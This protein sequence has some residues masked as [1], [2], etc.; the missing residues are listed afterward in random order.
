MPLTNYHTCFG[1]VD[2]FLPSDFNLLPKKDL[3]IMA[4][5]YDAI[6]NEI[7]SN[8]NSVGGNIVIY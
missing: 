3:F 4:I 7:K 5:G 2:I 8:I 6:L 1:F